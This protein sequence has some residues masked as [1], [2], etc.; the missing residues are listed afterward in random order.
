MSDEEFV[1]SNEWTL[2]TEFFFFWRKTANFLILNRV[3]PNLTGGFGLSEVKPRGLAS[4]E[5]L[6]RK[7]KPEGVG[8][9]CLCNVSTQ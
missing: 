5:K 3:Q 8:K 7:H 4:L 2:R 6:L 1:I 9:E